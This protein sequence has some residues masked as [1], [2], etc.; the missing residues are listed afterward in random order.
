MRLKVSR[1]TEAKDEIFNYFDAKNI[2]AE[3]AQALYWI[4]RIFVYLKRKSGLLKPIVRV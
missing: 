1:D 3:K 4:F 2:A